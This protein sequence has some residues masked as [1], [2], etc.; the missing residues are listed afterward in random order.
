MTPQAIGD[1][2]TQRRKARGLTQREL[3]DRTGLSKQTITSIETGT[4]NPRFESLLAYADA[5][6]MEWMVVPREVAQAL[7]SRVPSAPSPQSEQDVVLARLAALDQVAASQ[8]SRRASDKGAPASAD[9][10]A[11]GGHPVKSRR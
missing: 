6:D 3:I 7:K 2:L 4:G 5:L 11:P 1:A 9:G 8:R 10:D